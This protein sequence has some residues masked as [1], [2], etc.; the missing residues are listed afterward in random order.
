[1]YP[2]HNFF[3]MKG[4]SQVFFETSY[5]EQQEQDKSD[6]FLMGRLTRMGGEARVAREAGE[7]DV[8]FLSGEKR[9]GSDGDGLAASLP[10]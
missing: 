8:R 6:L 4:D 9:Q 3:L 2:H 5:G 1:M 10:S 7:G